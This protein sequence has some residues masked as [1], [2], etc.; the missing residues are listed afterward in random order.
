MTPEY[1]ISDERTKGQTSMHSG[2][3][4]DAAEGSTGGAS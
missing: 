4:Q 3:F 1:T 2:H